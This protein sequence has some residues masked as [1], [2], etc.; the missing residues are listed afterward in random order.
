[1]ARRAKKAITRKAAGKKHIRAKR[2]FR[3]EFGFVT[4]KGK[5]LKKWS[6][7]G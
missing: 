4:R 3:D 7:G 6:R 2:V 1:M 5:G